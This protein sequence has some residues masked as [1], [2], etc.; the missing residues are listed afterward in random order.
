MSGRARESG[1]ERERER[2]R[3]SESIGRRPV[4][5][6]GTANVARPQCSCVAGRRPHTTPISFLLMLLAG[7]LQSFRCVVN[8]S[9]QA[10]QQQRCC[11]HTT[12]LLV[13]SLFSAFP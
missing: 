13:L 10:K 9:P 5:A 6:L 4:H 12:L 1:S 11:G 8:L 2:E 3:D 7:K